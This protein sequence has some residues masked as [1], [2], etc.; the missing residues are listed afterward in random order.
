MQSS[1]FLGEDACL[2]PVHPRLTE[3]DVIY[4]A[5]VVGT[6]FDRLA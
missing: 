2:V 4:F 6:F 5:R 1:I 3:W